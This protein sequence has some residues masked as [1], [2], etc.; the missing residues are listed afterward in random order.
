MVLE[1]EAKLGE[2]LAAQ[3][4]GKPG[5]SQQ[6]TTDGH[7]AG[8]LPTLPPANTKKEFHLAQTMAARPEIV[9][10]VAE[11]RQYNP[12]GCPPRGDND[13]PLNSPL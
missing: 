3:T 1:A 7:M 4:G 5:G 11:R 8:A 13:L 6:R 9:E 10:L 12:L 2:M